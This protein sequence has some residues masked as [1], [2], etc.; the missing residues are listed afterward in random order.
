MKIV[1]VDLTTQLNSFRDLETKGRGGMVTSLF[2]LPNALSQIG[3]DVYVL[4]DAKDRGTTNFGV[5]WVNESD[6]PHLMRINFDFVVLNRQT[7][8]DC[9]DELKT[10]HRILW[11]HDMVHGGWIAKPERARSL[12]AVVFMS[13][14][15]Q[16][17]WNSYYRNLPKKQAII[18]NGVDKGL[19]YPQPKDLD[20][21]IY[22]SAPNRGLEHLPIIL[23]T[24]QAATGKNLKL[25]AFSNMK[26][27]HPQEKDKFENVYQ[28]VQSRGVDLRNPVPQYDLA[29]QVRRSGLMVKPSDFAETCSNTTIQSLAAGTPIVTG[30]TGADREWVKT[31]YNGIT[32]KHSLQDGPLFIMEI[33]RGVVEII[34]NEKFHKKLIK[35]APKTKGLYTWEKIGECWSRFLIR[36]F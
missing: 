33:C 19:F 18:P 12:S 30:P 15:S 23:E 16:E 29:V 27:L 7:Y 13:R 2:T 10:K 32:T 26:K 14:Y 1:F 22:F 8:G 20:Q 9:F 36:E 21:I 3:H 5:K 6:M 4:S 35:N 24:A 31:G 11:V 17:T 34:R 25:I 28:M